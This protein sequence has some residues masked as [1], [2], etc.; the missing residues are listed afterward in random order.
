MAMPDPPKH[1]PEH[2]DR[3]MQEHDRIGHTLEVSHPK[4]D[5]QTA[6]IEQFS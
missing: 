4:F 1:I 5:L 2:F 3:I 6:C